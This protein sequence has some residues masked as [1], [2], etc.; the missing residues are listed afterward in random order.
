MNNNYTNWPNILMANYM[1]RIAHGMKTAGTSNTTHTI[2]GLNMD[3]V[4]YKIPTP[5]ASVLINTVL[6]MDYVFNMHQMV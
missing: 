4:S 2:K 3:Y 6:N 5:Y 1:D